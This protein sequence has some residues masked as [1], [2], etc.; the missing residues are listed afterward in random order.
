M[1]FELFKM[2]FSDKKEREKRLEFCNNCEHKRDRWLGVFE[3]ESCGLCKCSIP[4]KVAL[5][6]SSCPIEK[7]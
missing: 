1:E 3:E 6:K 5:K 4:K 2:L 7:W